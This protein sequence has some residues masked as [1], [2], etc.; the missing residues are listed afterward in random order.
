MAALSL[1][2]DRNHAHEIARVLANPIFLHS[3][4]DDAR[5]RGE[6]VFEV[7]EQDAG[8]LAAQLDQPDHYVIDGEAFWATLTELQL[9]P[10]TAPTL[11]LLRDRPTLRG[12]LK[13]YGRADHRQCMRTPIFISEGDHYTP[14]VLGERLICKSKSGE[15]RGRECL[16]G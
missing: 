3:A 13:F 9:C 1:V 15:G 11:V 12:V 14:P 5:E 8:S 10:S 7:L 16:G 2:R 6:I 4:L